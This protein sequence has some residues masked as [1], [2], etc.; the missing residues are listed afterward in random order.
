[1][2]AAADK[3]L[4]VDEPEPWI[5]HLI[6]DMEKRFDRDAGRAAVDSLWTATYVLLGLEYPEEFANQLLRGV[7][8]M[9][10]SVT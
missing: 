7:R 9:K 5:L 8:S 4:R 1:M 6:R 2:T 10:E 3:V